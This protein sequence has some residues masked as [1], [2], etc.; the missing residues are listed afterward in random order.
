MVSG[1]VNISFDTDANAMYYQLAKG[2]VA[3]SAKARSNGIECILDYDADGALIGVEVL[4]MKKAL[5]LAASETSLLLAPLR[6]KMTRA[7]RQ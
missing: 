7:S 1:K 3:R 6:T 2:L 4:N 5:A